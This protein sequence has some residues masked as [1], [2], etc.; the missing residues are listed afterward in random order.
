MLLTEQDDKE[1]CARLERA[2][3]AARHALLISRRYILETKP[4]DPFQEDQALCV[5]TKA[6]SAISD[7][8]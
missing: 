6:L 7:I 1:R 4:V 2:L 3:E 5:I 8:H